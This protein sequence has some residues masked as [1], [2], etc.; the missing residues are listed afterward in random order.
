MHARLCC[1]RTNDN[2][3]GRHAL[4]TSEAAEPDTK[5]SEVREL[6]ARYL[7]GKTEIILSGSISDI[8]LGIEMSKGQP[9][10]SR[11]AEVGTDTDTPLGSDF[12]T[13]LRLNWK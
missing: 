10:M 5:S 12:T 8:L 11:D 4:Q 6:S 1:L 13:P 7:R 2:N 9:L 3:V